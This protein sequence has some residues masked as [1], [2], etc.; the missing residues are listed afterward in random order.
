[1][2]PTG[3]IP[4]RVP[5]KTKGVGRAELAEAAPTGEPAKIPFTKEA[6]FDVSVVEIDSLLGLMAVR[7]TFGAKS[8]TNWVLR[9]GLVCHTGKKCIE[10]TYRF[11]GVLR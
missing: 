2:R 4:R 9:G 3:K 10:D 6:S 7:V 1:M 5:G 11:I 8:V